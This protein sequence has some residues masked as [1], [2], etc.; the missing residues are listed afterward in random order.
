[1]TINHHTPISFGALRSTANLNTPLSELDSA[2]TGLLAGTTPFDPGLLTL[3][4]LP[5][6][7]PTAGR[8]LL[9]TSA[10]RL[11]VKTSSAT[12]GPLIQRPPAFSV[13]Q[14]NHTTVPTATPTVVRFNS[15][16][17]D[18][19]GC[20]NTSTY[21]FT[22]PRTGVWSLNTTIT[23]QLAFGGSYSWFIQLYINGAFYLSG[24]NL[25][26]DG[27]TAHTEFRFRVTSLS[28]KYTIVVYQATGSDQSVYASLAY[29]FLTGVLL[30]DE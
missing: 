24:Y 5:A 23:W 22:P 14:S 27:R 2:I 13:Y 28:D 26:N 19:G 1:M 6:I 17:W 8:S 10:G 18:F 4:N 29:T 30:R 20:F 11:Y 9:F 12:Y 15:L 21:E 3:D 25:L 7:T 16:L